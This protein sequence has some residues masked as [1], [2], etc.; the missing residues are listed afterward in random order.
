MIED[1]LIEGGAIDISQLEAGK[2]CPPGKTR[3]ASGLCRKKKCG[4]GRTRSGTGRCHKLRKSGPKRARAPSSPRYR[5]RGG[6]VP[7][8][9]LAGGEVPAPAPELTL[10]AG[11]LE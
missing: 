9:E 2:K 11:A 8:V 5:V 7:E 3:G 4:R 1:V 10:T 6:E